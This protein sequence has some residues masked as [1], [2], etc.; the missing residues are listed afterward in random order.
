MLKD[1]TQP[2]TLLLN[3]KLFYKSMIVL[4]AGSAQDAS[5]LF[6][7]FADYILNRAPST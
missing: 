2:W 6:L 5:R 4:H 1:T 3:E 7:T